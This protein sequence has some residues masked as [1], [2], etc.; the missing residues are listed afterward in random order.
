M[1]KELSIEKPKRLEY[2]QAYK[3]L[4]S[5]N[6]KLLMTNS[7]IKM[8]KCGNNY[9]KSYFI[10]WNT[11]VYEYQLGKKKIAKLFMK[12]YSNTLEK[13]FYQWKTIKESIDFKNIEADN[14]ENLN[15]YLFLVE[16]VNDLEATLQK[17][18]DKKKIIS[19]TFARRMF[20][21]VEKKEIFLCFNT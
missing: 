20:F 10:I 12:V 15:K 14:K 11:R 3:N 18:S 16:K 1:S 6:Q 21:Y 17:V 19:A 13:R 9:V 5:D 4:F 2:E 7:L 8:L